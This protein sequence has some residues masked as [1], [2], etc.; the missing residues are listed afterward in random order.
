MSVLLGCYVVFF[1]KQKTAY[2]MRISDWSSDVCSSDL[3]AERQRRHRGAEVGGRPEGLE[4]ERVGEE[5]DE[6]L[7]PDELGREPEGVLDQQR[8]V[9]RLRGRP[10]E[11]DG[12]DGELRQDQQV[13]QG[14]GDRKSTRLNSSH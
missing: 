13:G 8:L 10:Q 12:G 4:V 3:Q 9:E 7:E 11:E 6:V 5:V 2:E 14:R 1:F